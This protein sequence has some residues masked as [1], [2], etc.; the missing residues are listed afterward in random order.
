MLR[1]RNITLSSS[2]PTEVTIEDSVQSSCTIVIQNTADT[3]Y[4]YIGTSSVS[5]LNYGYKIFPG[6][7]FTVELSAFSHL[8]A[9]GSSNSTTCSVMVIERAI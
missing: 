7:G 4:V 9:V 6:Q 1:T 8:Y 3:G 5:N 2:V